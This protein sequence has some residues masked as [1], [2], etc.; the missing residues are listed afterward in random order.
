MNFGHEE[1][2]PGNFLQFFGNGIGMPMYSGIFFLKF[3]LLQIRSHREFPG[4]AG[5]LLLK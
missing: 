1:F 4:N 5:S 2:L 3:R